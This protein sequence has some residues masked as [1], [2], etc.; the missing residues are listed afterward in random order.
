MSPEPAERGRPS[1]ARSFPR[2]AELDAL[3]D[4]FERGDY[5]HV[6]RAAPQLARRTEDA[7][8]AAAARELRARIEPDPV[9]LY[10][11]ALVGALLVFLTVWFVGHAH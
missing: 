8:V 11:L 2:Q 10:L 7:A 6:R 3:V 9:A 1:F 5:A 4:A